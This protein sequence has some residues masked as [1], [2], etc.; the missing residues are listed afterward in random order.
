MMVFTTAI[1]LSVAYLIKGM[2]FSF[3]YL[4]KEGKQQRAT[5]HQHYL[6]EKAEIREASEQL[7]KTSGNELLNME[8]ENRNPRGQRARVKSLYG[9]ANYRYGGE[10]GPD[11]TETTLEGKAGIASLVKYYHGEI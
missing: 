8:Y 5:E 11:K 2:T 10:S 1:G 9:I 6:R 7:E 3:V 4:S